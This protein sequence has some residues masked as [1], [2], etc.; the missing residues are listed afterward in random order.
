[1]MKWNISFFATTIFV[2]L[3][4]SCRVAPAGAGGGTG[5]GNV[6][7]KGPKG[8]ATFV[9]V[10][11][12]GDTTIYFAGPFVYKLKKGKGKIL[13]DHTY[14]S[15]KSAPSSV[16]CNYTLITNQEKFKP[17]SLKLMLAKNNI[18][19]KEFEKFFAEAINSHKF[20][21]RYSFTTTDVVFNEWMNTYKP[22]LILNT[23]MRFLPTNSFKKYSRSVRFRVLFDKFNE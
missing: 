16:V 18:E 4:S 17:E 9:K 22:E 2:L 15:V 14:Y 21:Y 11:L 7:S 10:F 8:P 12:K 3:I 5:K 6:S 20:R 23:E 1:M 13:M 19:I